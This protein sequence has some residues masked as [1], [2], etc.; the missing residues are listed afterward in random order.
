MT[1][2][3][4]LTCDTPLFT[5]RRLSV[6]ALPPLDNL[7]LHG[8]DPQAMFVIQSGLVGYEFFYLVLP[9]RFLYFTSSS[10]T[11]TSYFSLSLRLTVVLLINSA[12]QYSNLSLF[13]RVHVSILVL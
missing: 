4:F 6:I 5:A 9:L 8:E 1:N 12:I 7:L 13:T 2:Q 3:C 11:S 10:S